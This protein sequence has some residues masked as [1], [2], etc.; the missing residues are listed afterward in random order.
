[1]FDNDVL[2]T[3]LL[4]CVLKN[5]ISPEIIASELRTDK[6]TAENLIICLI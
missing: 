3:A 2:M 1:M 5:A 6:S 4:P